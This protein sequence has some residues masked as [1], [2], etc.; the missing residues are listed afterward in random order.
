MKTKIICALILGAIFL[1][2]FIQADVIPPDMKPLPGCT[3]IANLSDF[4]D[5]ALFIYTT[6]PMIQGYQVSEIKD[7]ECVSK[8]YKFNSFRIY[9]VKK[10]YL[11][12][13]GIS[14]IDFNSDKNVFAADEGTI[15]AGLGYIA[16]NDKRTQ[17]DR[18]YSI[19][20]LSQNKLVLYESK[21]ITKYENAADKV[22]TWSSPDA[23]P[24]PQPQKKGFFYSVWC[25]VK[26]IFGKAC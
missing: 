4:P 1:P 19:V 24:Q 22:E 17:E 7:G 12:Q 2:L 23:S 8:G 9:A 10:E 11:N 6:G 26:K 20:G 5:I 25:F 15:L 14:N 13:K 21:R 18:F 16:Q 3:K